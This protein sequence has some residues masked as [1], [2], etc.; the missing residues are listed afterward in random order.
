M[1]KIILTALAVFAFG[2]TNAQKGKI[3]AKIN[4]LGALFGR[5]DVSGEYIVSDSFGVELSLGVAFGKSSGISINGSEKPTQ[6][7]F[8]VKVTA[9]YYFNPDQGADGWY[10]GV[11]LRQ[12]SLNLSYPNTFSNF[13]Y[14]SSVFAGGVEF[15]KKWVFDSGLL[16]ELGAGVGR[17]FSE[18]RTFTNSSSDY[19]GNFEIGIDFTGKFAVGYRF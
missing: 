5:P 8:G 6:S 4:P 3:E 9:K 10:G 7:G 16:I 15:G 19:D 11:Y 17:P 14:K 1:K 12:E 2:L 13:D 18:K